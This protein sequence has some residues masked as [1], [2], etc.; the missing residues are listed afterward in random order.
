M[1]SEVSLIFEFKEHGAK[2][3]KYLWLKYLF[4]LINFF[5]ILIFSTK[6]VQISIKKKHPKNELDRDVYKW[7]WSY[8][9]KGLIGASKGEISKS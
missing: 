1:G 8:I 5:H 4:S 7:S 9:L 3:A 2:T 6:T